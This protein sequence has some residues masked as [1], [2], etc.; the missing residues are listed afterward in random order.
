MGHPPVIDLD[1]GIDVEWL[2]K[3][4][5]FANL[6]LRDYELHRKWLPIIKINLNP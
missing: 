4:L 5:H 2:E 1:E 6:L 3:V